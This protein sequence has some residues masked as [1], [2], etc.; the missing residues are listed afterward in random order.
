MLCSNFG[1]LQEDTNVDVATGIHHKSVHYKKCR[2]QPQLFRIKTILTN[3][4]PSISPILKQIKYVNHYNPTKHATAKEKILLAHSPMAARWRA[5]HHH[6]TKVA[7][8]MLQGRCSAFEMPKT[9]SLQ[10]GTGSGELK[11]VDLTI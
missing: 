10:T 6:G 4:K 8:D 5:P 11:V 3:I 2:W 7:N 9:A 1:R